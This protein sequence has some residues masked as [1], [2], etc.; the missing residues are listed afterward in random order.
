[1]AAELRVR[2]TASVVVVLVLVCGIIVGACVGWIVGA[3]LGQRAT[4]GCIEFECAV[5]AVWKLGGV[6][7]G[8]VAGSLLGWFLLTLLR[9]AGN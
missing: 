1:M 6:F 9:R 4:R 7:I 5:S 2:G 8:I 3:E